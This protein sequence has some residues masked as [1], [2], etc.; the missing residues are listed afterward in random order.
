MTTA[1]LTLP[2]LVLLI[3]A[4]AALNAIVEGV[5]GVGLN[6]TY[7]SG[8]LSKIGRGL[9]NLIMGER[10][11][12]WLLQLAPWTGLVLGALCGHR[13]DLHFGREALWL[14]F[15]ISLLIAGG[16]P[17]IPASR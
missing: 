8:A 15:A 11:S 1:T 9:G 17:F 10:D 5:A 14:P 2:S 12:E 3:L 7:V 16:I 13:L 6:L 4:M